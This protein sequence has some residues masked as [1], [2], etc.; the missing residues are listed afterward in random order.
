MQVY[1]TGLHKDVRTYK[2]CINIHTQD[3]SKCPGKMVEVRQVDLSGMKKKIKQIKS[4][5]HVV[6]VV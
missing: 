5:W 1:Q 2:L 6:V 4:K 3:Y